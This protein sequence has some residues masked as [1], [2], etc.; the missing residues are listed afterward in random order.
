MLFVYP[1]ASNT[2]KS[3][4][5][6]PSTSATLVILAGGA[7]HNYQLTKPRGRLRTSSPAAAATMVILAGEVVI[8]VLVSL[9]GAGRHSQGGRG[10]H[11]AALWR[12][13]GP[14][15]SHP[16]GLRET[17]NTQPIHC[18]GSQKKGRRWVALWR[19]RGPLRAHPLGLRGKK[20]TLRICFV[21]VHKRVAKTP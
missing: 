6:A 10:T 14:L 5:M 19:Y 18:R 17:F 20:I 1:V 9:L 16:F 15:R 11:R 3:L 2:K 4:I 7:D 13:R 8:V 12:H 21:G